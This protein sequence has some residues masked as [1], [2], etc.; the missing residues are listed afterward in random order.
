M[1]KEIETTY[2]VLLEG[3]IILYP[4]DTIWGLGCD[5]TNITAVRK[6]FEI[7]KRPSKKSMILLV[8]SVEM[9]RHYVTDDNFK[10]I[11]FLN[12]QKE[13]TTGIFQRAVNLPSALIHSDGTVALRITKDPF[14]RKLINK[15][16]RPIVSTSANFSGKPTAAL[17]TDIDPLIKDAV[18]YIVNYR[19][20]ATAKATPSRIVKLGNGDEVIF[21]R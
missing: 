7:K 20:D 14:C 1:N 8:N 18:D 13:P 12:E 9:L 2:R 10:L 15:L 19:Q 4:T 3:N 21:L 17:F 16:E 11:N 5:A 6:I